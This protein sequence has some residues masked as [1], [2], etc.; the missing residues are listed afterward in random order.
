MLYGPKRMKEGADG[1]R[2]AAVIVVAC[3]TGLTV[4][5]YIGLAIKMAFKFHI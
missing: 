1:P 2:A 3:A 5:A 4:G